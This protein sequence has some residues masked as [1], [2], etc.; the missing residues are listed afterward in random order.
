MT[1]G[2]ERS[3][4][5][6]GTA[7]AV[8]P[9]FLSPGHEQ[10]AEGEETRTRRAIACAAAGDREALRYLYERY[11]GTVYRYVRCLVRDEH[12]AQDLTQSVF[13][14]LMR[15]LDRYDEE[16]GRF[17][18][19]VLRV[20]HNVTVDYIR[21]VRPV[22]ASDVWPDDAESDEVGNRCRWALHDAL[23][24]LSEEQREVLVLRQIVGLRPG[25]IAERM[26]KTEG[27]VHALH[28][29]ARASMR[30][31]LAH[32]NAAPAIRRAAR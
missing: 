2:L 9:L 25:E 4:S 30:T 29:R 15:I 23:A 18:S 11:S 22:V 31:S 14:K 27:S 26:A 20:A 13:L 1:I 10:D 5:V 3:A 32:A 17:V 7:D 8:S 21:L 6:S 24:A 28:H 19:W 16:Q 12:E